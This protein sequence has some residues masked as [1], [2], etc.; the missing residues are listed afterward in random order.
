M[1]TAVLALL[2]LACLFVGWMLNFILPGARISAWSILALGAALMAAAVM[3]DRRQVGSALAGRRGKLGVGATVRVSLF[4]GILLFANAISV[5]NYYRFDFTGLAQFTLT[6][7]TK[8]VL[9]K[10]DGP[11]EIVS[12]VK[13]GVAS[14]V[15]R[16]AENLLAEYQVHSDRLTVRAVD[17]D[18]SPD[19]ARRYGV[20]QI[21]ALLG[22]VVFT[23]EAGRKRVFGPQI[24]GAAEHAFTGALLEVTGTKQ[25]KVYFLTGHGERRI[26]ADYDSV[27]RGLRDNL[28]QV[29]ELDLLT[30]SG[31][32]EDAAAV[33]L[34]GPRRPLVAGEVQ[35]LRDYLE[36]DGR[37]FVLLDPDP[38]R[39]LRQLLS[40]WWLDIE[41]GHI[42]DPGAHVAPRPDIPLVD[43]TR[44]SFG[45]AEVYFPGA[46]ALLPRAE[47]PDG[48]ELSALA[49][50]SPESWLEKRVTSGVEPAFDQQS[51]RKGPLAI[52]ALVSTTPADKAAASKG[53]RLA[54]IGDSDF[55][56]NPHFHNGNNGD[57][58]L[59]TVN[60]LAAGEEIISVDRK[61]L[62][63]RRLVLSPEEAR[64]LHVSSIGLLPLLLLLAG[65]YV[66]WRRR[67]S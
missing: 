27:R 36:D 26:D 33:V 1:G 46:T 24:A 53:A 39:A 56:A 37:L 50:S 5:G 35:S 40:E 16:Y 30:G 2:G 20:D 65:A 34:A 21:G 54:V 13:P 18:L 59:T 67:L 17:P 45:L 57:L 9:A 42:L 23:G 38:P 66:W 52:G 64:F 41:A 8:D 10:L 3:I 48:V 11:V 61:A 43:R 12:F 55:I 32:P 6:S 49:W 62:A 31:V 15:G 19:Q 58:F 28:F 7:Q 47:A 29:A 22:A 63:I 25:K 60:W 4:V 14:P 44:N 51:D